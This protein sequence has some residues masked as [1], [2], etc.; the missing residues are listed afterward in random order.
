MRKVT[1]TRL[2]FVLSCIPR[3]F[4]LCAGEIPTDHASRMAA[5]AELFS[6]E[7]GPIFREHCLECHGGGAKLKSGFSLA[8][9][10]NLLKGG[11][12]GLTVVAQNPGASPLVDY[13]RH[14]EEPFMPP[15]KPMLA[16]EELDAIEQW[17]L[18]GAAYDKPLAEVRGEG[19]PLKVT[20]EDRAYW[21][22]R[23]LEEVNPPVGSDST[24]SR[25]AIDRFVA[26]E[27]DERGLIASKPVD[28]TQLLRRAWFDVIGL[29]PTQ[30]AVKAFGE[31]P[32]TEAYQ[33]VIDK[34]L[35]SEHFGERWARHWLDIARFAESHG[36]EHDTDRE[37]AYHYRDFVIRAFNADMPYDQFVR[38]QIAGDEMAPDN[39]LALMA[40]GFLGAGVFPT[41][42]TIN[43]AERVRYDALDDMV[44]TMGTAMLASTI[45]CARCHDH[46]YDPIPT[47]DYYSLLAAFTTTVRTEVPV[48]TWKLDPKASEMSE[49]NRPEAE[50]VM[51]CSEGAH[52]KPMRLAT[53]SGKIPDFYDQTYLLNR[54]DVNQKQ[55]V[56][57]LGFL[58]VLMK[59][60]ADSSYWTAQRSDGAKTSLRR[61]GVANWITDTERGA[62]HLLA[63]VI[64]NRIWQHYF[65]AGLVATPNDFG[66]Q[67]DEPSHPE[68]L[69]WL[70]GELIQNG[71]RLKPLHRMILLSRAYQLG[72]SESANEFNRSVDSENRYLWMRPA[73][74]LEA[75][76]I[77]DAAL[78]AT[79]ALDETL[80]GAGT[81]DFKMK[82]RSVY[83][84]VKRSK[85]IPMLQLY[86]WPDALTSLGQRSVTTT[87]AQALV[88]INSP[89]MRELANGFAD[90]LQESPDPVGDAYFRAL[91][92]A[93]TP[94]ERERAQ[95]FIER[96]SSSRE[97]DRVAALADFC[98]ALMGTNEFVYVE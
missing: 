58:T 57:T 71:W 42:I 13:V 34:L 12:Q 84:K 31:D 1:S 73:R 79:G 72:A 20:D 98:Q 30:D 81:L 5:S 40:T 64:V 17:I 27:H 70:A 80:Y 82:R 92:R 97:G 53:S 43:D 49:G 51:I 35:G 39:P 54:G 33:K 24:W 48:D 59:D 78:A 90:A 52:I 91:G 47:R 62:G 69:D 38:W 36:F 83:F 18:L 75:E 11:D 76:A 16:Q 15:K 68:L 55:E 85:L 23:K 88:F 3:V 28:R 66:F 21:A 50:K 6:T 2:L 94:A 7:V 95:L 96:Q 65:G 9:R 29:P 22:Y 86:D 67:G 45:G 74:R 46:K 60:G 41:Q 32:E 25:A 63:R 14:R 10:A 56:A 37:F 93:P 89:E 4:S 26:A 19:A 77:R 8:T 44:A 87:P 61:S